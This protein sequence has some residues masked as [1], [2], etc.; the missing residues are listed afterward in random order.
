MNDQDYFDELET[1]KIIATTPS[2]FYRILL[3]LIILILG[4]AIG[5]IWYFL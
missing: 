1:N 3:W 4:G 2:S 5:A